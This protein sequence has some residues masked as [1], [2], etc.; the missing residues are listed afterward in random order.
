MFV[1]RSR[2][3]AAR[4]ARRGLSL[5]H[6]IAPS[7]PSSSFVE[8]FTNS[9]SM[10]KSCVKSSRLTLKILQKQLC[11]INKGLATTQLELGVLKADVKYGVYHTIVACAALTSAALAIAAIQFRKS[12]RY[13]FTCTDTAMH[14]KNLNDLCK[15]TC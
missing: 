2:F 4:V 8:T 11:A 14:A 10:A 13:T 9:S 12:K 7:T 15:T 1:T 5:L 3:A 6:E